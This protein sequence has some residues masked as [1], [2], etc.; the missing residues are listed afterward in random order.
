MNRSVKQ[1]VR[2]SKNFSFAQF[3]KYLGRFKTLKQAVKSRKNNCFRWNNLGNDLGDTIGHTI[4]SIFF[5]Q[6]VSVQN[7]DNLVLVKFF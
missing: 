1:I 4:D 2:F 6:L 3:S 7:F 5:E